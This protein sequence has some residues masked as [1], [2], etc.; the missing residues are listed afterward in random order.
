L[1]ILAEA[2]GSAIR[3][4]TRMS[5]WD[6]FGDT[7]PYGPLEVPF[8]KRAQLAAS[9]LQAAGVAVFTDL[10]RLTAFADN[11]IPHVLALDGILTLDPA[12]AERIEAGQ[13]LTHDSPEE[14]ELRACTVHAIELLSTACGHRL[15]PAQIDMLLWTRGQDPRYKAH[16]RPRARSTAY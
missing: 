4:V 15:S 7:S 1:R 2:G 10:D 5:G 14:V 11:L 16:P 12:L 3:L 6:C 8:F 13:L 9:D